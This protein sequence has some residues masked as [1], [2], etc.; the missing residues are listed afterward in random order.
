MMSLRKSY[1]Y[2][3]KWFSSFRRHCSSTSTQQ[4]LVERL[5]EV[6]LGPKYLGTSGV[7]PNSVKL[8][9]GAISVLKDILMKYPDVMRKGSIQ[10]YV[11]IG[12]Y[13]VPFLVMDNLV[14]RMYIVPPNNWEAE[15]HCAVSKT[16]YD[17][18][19]YHDHSYNFVSHTLCGLQVNQ[20]YAVTSSPPNPRADDPLLNDQWWKYCYTPALTPSSSTWR[21]HVNEPAK[22]EP[23]G[24]VYMNT[25]PE[26][27][28]SKGDS[29]AMQHEEIH[30]VWFYPDSKSKWFA[31]LFWESV[32]A[33]PPSPTKLAYSPAYFDKLPFAEEKHRMMK[34]DEV[35]VLMSDFFTAL[36]H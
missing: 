23:I 7:F 26:E 20:R 30:R 24:R 22:V 21:K 36:G 34:P 28:I 25:F 12:V 1:F 3:N 9:T 31:C 2:T 5:S 11:W 29:Y 27:N 4:Q 16:N 17:D 13:A 6:G 33:K 8:E 32:R 10:N 35:D 14:G 15:Q 19:F 18:F